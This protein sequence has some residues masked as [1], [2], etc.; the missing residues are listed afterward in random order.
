VDIPFVKE[1]DFT[2]GEVNTLSPLIRRVICENPGPFTYTGSGTYLIGHREIAIIDPGPANDAHT[3]ALLNAIGDGTLTHILVTHTHSDHC[4]GVAALKAATGATVYGY[5]AHPSAPGDAAPALD[6][7]ADF[8]YA[9]D[10]IITNGD[11]V[12]TDEWTLKAIHTPG[13]ISN[14]LCFELAAE[15]A[16]F[17]GDHMMGWATTVV[18]PPDGNM[19]DYLASLDVL[20]ARDDAIYYPTH[21]APITNPRQFTK[22]VKIHRD[23]RD[24][25][26]LRQ[27]EAGPQTIMTMVKVIY[28]DVDPRLHLAA[29]LNVQAHLVRH[30]TSGRVAMTGESLLQAEYTLV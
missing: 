12:E 11:S 26:I 17:T 4:G 20:L 2:Y 24:Q 15:K 25:Q 22:A 8:S 16:L 6:E 28:A 1:F 27:L 9:P 30:V 18:A 14:H 19:E 10:E 5:G 23:M 21:G 13:H 7:G 29:A 3:Q